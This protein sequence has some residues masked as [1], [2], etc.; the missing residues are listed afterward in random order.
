MS[1]AVLAYLW[2]GDIADDGCDE[3]Y[4]YMALFWGIIDLSPSPHNANP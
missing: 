3:D 1:W 2:L 4:Y